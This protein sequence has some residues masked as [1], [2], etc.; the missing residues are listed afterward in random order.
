MGNNSSRAK[1]Y[2]GTDVEERRLSFANTSTP[3]P[4]AAADP[5]ADLKQ[6]RRQQRDASPGAPTTKQWNPDS[7]PVLT[8]ADSRAS[9]VRRVSEK[10]ETW[11]EL[12]DGSFAEHRSPAFAV[13]GSCTADAA[14]GGAARHRK[15]HRSA[16]GVQE[17]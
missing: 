7:G 16:Q 11:V 6:Q 3:S 17:G 4:P 9:N 13:G 14:A 5:L 12:P 2:L 10:I 8:E 15:V 1:A